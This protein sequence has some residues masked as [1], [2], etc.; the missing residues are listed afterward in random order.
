M[1][2]LVDP[3][4]FLHSL[5]LNYLR[6]LSDSNGPSSI[7]FGQNL[8]SISSNF[9]NQ[10]N[11]SI[12]STISTFNPY[13]E[14]SGLADS[15]R[16]PELLVNGSPPQ[17]IPNQALNLDHQNHLR[18]RTRRPI[19]S[20]PS[21]NR[22][23]YSETIVGPN[24]SGLSVGM[25]VSGRKSFRNSKHSSKL[26]NS[27]ITQS[28][29]NQIQ[30]SKLIHKAAN[31]LQNVLNIN[32]NSIIPSNSKIQVSSKIHLNPQDSEDDQLK[33]NLLTPFR[34]SRLLN[35]SQDPSNNLSSTPSQSTNIDLVKKHRRRISAVTFANSSFNL[36]NQSNQTPISSS[37]HLLN[38]SERI[39][40]TSSMAT[41]NTF[42]S[43]E[44]SELH[45]HINLNSP[46]P[47]HLR[48]NS[49]VSSLDLKLESNDTHQSTPSN[50]IQT[51]S[52]FIPSQNDTGAYYCPDHDPDKRLSDM[53]FNHKPFNLNRLTQVVG[54]INLQ[55]TPLLEVENE[56][57]D[58]GDEGLDSDQT[59]TGTEQGEDDSS[60]N[61]EE[62]VVVDDDDDEIENQLRIKSHK[63][64][65][66]NDT[67]SI[68]I[69][70]IDLTIAE[71]T[72]SSIGK[73][74][75]NTISTSV[76]DSNSLNKLTT[77][78]AESALLNNVMDLN[79]S[80]TQSPPLL[81]RRERRRVNIKMGKLVGPPIIEEDSTGQ[82]LD[83]ISLSKPINS[84]SDLIK[85]NLP[86]ARPSLPDL[87]RAIVNPN[88]INQPESYHNYKP[89][90]SSVLLNGFSPGR[91]RSLTTPTPIP[92]IA[93][94]NA[95]PKLSTFDKIN[96]H[97][98]K[99]ESLTS[100]PSRTRSE[101]GPTFSKQKKAQTQNL[102]SQIPLL[103]QTNLS[104][105]SPQGLTNSDKTES[106]ISTKSKRSQLVFKKIPI[107]ADS[108][109]IKPIIQKSI[110]TQLLTA[111]S[112]SS[113]IDN[114]FRCFYAL[115]ASKERN[116]LKL[117]LYY[118]F[119]KEPTKPI[120]TSIKLDVC[121]EEVVGFAL[122]SYV[123]EMREPKLSE[124]R[125]KP[126]GLDLFETHAWCLRL[127]EDDGEV[128]EDFP[129]LERIRPASKVGSNEFAIVM[130]TEA[131]AKQ[132]ATA[133]AQI[134]RR[135]SRILGQ[136]Q[137]ATGVSTESSVLSTG[138]NTLPPPI[139]P[140][141]G[142]SGITLENSRTIGGG[143]SGSLSNH[144]FG[145]NTA[146]GSSFS[147][148]PVYLKIRIPSP[149]RG[150][151]SII[152]TM[153][154]SVDMY[155]ADVLE[156]LVK[157]KSLGH[158]KEWALLVPSSPSIPV[159]QRDI[160]VPLDRTVQSLQ[161][162]NS[163]ALVKRTQVSSK[164]LRNSH[165][166]AS[167]GTRNTN[168]SASIFKRLS[169]TPQPK[170]VSVTDLTSTNRTFLIQT[171]R[172]GILGKQERLLTIEDD[173]IHIGPNQGMMI[174]NGGNINNN[175]LV[176]SGKTSSYHI[177]QIID[178]NLRAKVGLKLI[179]IRESGEK[180]Y[181]VEAENSQSAVEIVRHIRG[182]K[183]M[184][185][186]TRT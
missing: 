121:V 168:P 102:H 41:I 107:Q 117:T 184:Y 24:S 37:S 90:R 137:K 13:I 94:S 185:H 26:S 98:N 1:S 76:L 38:K 51:T 126:N 150:V 9:P 25:R 83:P 133:Q 100:I 167:F 89:I 155:L 93:I 175:N 22:L 106:K 129:A 157:K 181:D 118:P 166:N 47:S 61:L 105:I 108:K 111:K 152:T 79:S 63:L 54:S 84:I 183:E 2:L 125:H 110:L 42:T 28:N 122:W 87:R 82:T 112:S 16:W 8:S 40:L 113:S 123:E 154:V 85:N 164:L 142:T 68:S 69:G 75:S 46:T 143:L 151:D 156:T 120:K 10:T 173:Y 158:V 81:R 177:S 95:T 99:I 77:T 179:V 104:N 162:V 146:G 176:G 58:T 39:D 140:I 64:H 119:S 35:P 92:N 88:E 96:P 115:L 19:H 163:L 72:G 136:P 165:S 53:L 33:S 31:Q 130:A 171:K 148:L 114:P 139:N 170:Y 134:Q 153:N 48:Q 86:S 56:L 23:K 49:N 128:D 30:T 66:K 20:N 131:Q 159:H 149:G 59:D 97:M 178:C 116:A 7:S 14:L 50:S 124:I 3:E 172:R 180:R 36:S 34:P 5:K 17:P 67:G 12:L 174:G 4:Y 80:I 141:T 144:R 145:M 186:N 109:S 71:D 21:G 74:L 78:P 73:S 52:A 62:E 147:G 29:L 135:P 43:S 132:N 70:S 18:N 44:P 169:E 45:H 101:S 65:M 32:S 6:K 161:G 15:Q 57:D 11:Q 55:P 27:S 182:L 103:T 127:V 138:V 91:A 60:L 160:L